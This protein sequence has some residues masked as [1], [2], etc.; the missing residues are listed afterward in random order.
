M[1]KIPLAVCLVISV[2]GAGCIYYSMRPNTPLEFDKI[3]VVPI[4]N[5][6]F[7]PQ[8]QVLLTKQVRTR[9]A[10]I[11]GLELAS[12]PENAAVL[13]ITIVDFGRSVATTQ[14]D[15][16][17]R[18]KSFNVKM[19]IVCALRNNITGKVYFKDYRIS[20]FVECHMSNNN[21]QAFQYQAIPK[22]TNKLAN[23]VCDIICNLW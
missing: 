20:D 9:L 13:E 5:D 8:A 10:N 23:K 18:A 15:D 14:E 4:K 6:S 19:A 1:K 2:L 3:Y 22:L 16:T 11:A 12:S 17:S 21:F 7:A